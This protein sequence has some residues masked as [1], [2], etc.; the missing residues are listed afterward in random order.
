[1]E[2]FVVGYEDD[3]IIPGGYPVTSKSYYK[4]Y[5]DFRA[6][7][8]G[9]RRIDVMGRFGYT[10]QAEIRRKAVRMLAATPDI[11]FV[12]VGGKVRYSRFLREAASARL[13]V[14]LPGNGPFTHRV[15]EFLGLGTCM[16]S[17]RFTTQLHVPLEPG[18]H[19]VDVADDLSDLVDKCRH[20]IRRDLARERVASAG[21]D[22]F[23]RYLQCDQLAGYHMRCILGRL[24]SPAVR[25]SEQST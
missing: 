20:Y 10:F 22:F 15:A 17:P 5:T 23:D 18:V 9:G 19:Y 6:D 12:G 21:R 4:Y 7:D 11:G 13:S 25:Q 2:N 16:I 1:M 8:A 3:R 24:G 14:H